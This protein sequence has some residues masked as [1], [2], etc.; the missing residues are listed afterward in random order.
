MTTHRKCTK[1]GEEKSLEDFSPHARG[2]FG[3]QP[4]CKACCVEA[5]RVR[6]FANHEVNREKSRL[7]ALKDQRENSEARNAA[8]RA[9]V[10]RNP[11][12]D[13]AS[14]DQWADA[15]P[16]QVAAIKNAWRKANLA[17]FNETG[18]AWKKANP[19]AMKKYRLRK[20]GLTLEQY[21]AMLVEQGGR[22]AICET[23]TPAKHG[24]WCIDHEHG[25]MKVRGLL[26]VKCNAGLG[27]FD[28]S[29]GF[30]LAAERY[31]QKAKRQRRVA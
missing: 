7:R 28:D 13:R 9:W 16:E 29:P 24:S 25:S 15:H 2:K 21:D 12:A 1:C 31:L 23:S 19:S 5:N 14:K 22:C 30:L 8:R 18:K 17:R 6:Y 27:S 4:Q 26:C 11:E 10:D 3:R 20:Y